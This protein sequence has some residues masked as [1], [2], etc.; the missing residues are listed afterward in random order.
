MSETPFTFGGTLGGYSDAWGGEYVRARELEPVRVSW[1]SMDPLWPAELAFGYVRSNPINLI[2]PYGLQVCP[3]P[4]CAAPVAVGSAP[5]CVIGLGIVACWE[6]T[7]KAYW[8]IYGNRSVD[9]Q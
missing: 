1:M 4:D 3:P 5:V 2:D 7:W 8:P 9:R 6:P